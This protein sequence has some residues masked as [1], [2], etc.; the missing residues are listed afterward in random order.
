MFASKK[1]LES[2][3]SSLSLNRRIW[4]FNVFLLNAFLGTY[5]V[6]FMGP[7][8]VFPVVISKDAQ[9]SPHYKPMA[10]SRSDD[11]P[12]GIYPLLKSKD[13]GEFNTSV[14][15]SGCNKAEPHPFDPKKPSSKQIEANNWFALAQRFYCILEEKLPSIYSADRDLGMYISDGEEFKKKIDTMRRCPTGLVACTIAKNEG[16]FIQEWVAFHALMGYEHFYIYVNNA[17]D[18]TLAALKP[19]IDIG[20]VT[21]IEQTGEEMQCKAMKQCFANIKENH[22]DRIQW[23]AIQDVDEYV[24]LPQPGCV[25]DMLQNYVNYSAL[26]LNWNLFGTDHEI[27]SKPKDA[28]ITEVYTHSV[29]NHHVKSIANVRNTKECCH[30]HY[31]KPEEGAIS[32][33]EN[34]NKVREYQ[35]MKGGRGEK[36]KMNHYMKKSFEDLLAKRFRGRATVKDARWTP[37][38]FYDELLAES[39]PDMYELDDTISWTQPYMRT[40]LNVR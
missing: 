36:I 13:I 4:I 25:V 8:G 22:Q 14:H 15:K 16:R 12:I 24:F 9:H 7:N 19:F 38:Y 28:L 17:A 40:L 10:E 21:A 35:N 26:A 29:L 20:L 2:L 3:R 31:C 6:E 23:V 32:V 27:F 39:T 18:H 34:L 37:G 33:D 1:M 30:A 11:R 5:I